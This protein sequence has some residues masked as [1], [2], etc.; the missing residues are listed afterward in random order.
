LNR[1]ENYNAEARNRLCGFS[2]I[3]NVCPCSCGACDPPPPPPPPLQ[4]GFWG[5]F[6]RRTADGLDEVQVGK[7]NEGR[8]VRQCMEACTTN[9]DCQFFL[10]KETGSNG[11]YL[12][13]CTLYS[14]EG[15]VCLRYDPSNSSV[16]NAYVKVPGGKLCDESSAAP[17]CAL[18]GNGACG[19]PYRK[20]AAAA[21]PPKNCS[22]GG[23]AVVDDD[24][25]GNAI[26]A[27]V[28]QAVDMLANSTDSTEPALEVVETPE[29]PEA[30]EAEAPAWPVPVIVAA[31][32]VFV[33]VAY[34]IK[35]GKV[36]LPELGLRRSLA[37]DSMANQSL[38]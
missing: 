5:P 7:R 8:T 28:Q 15:G 23:G 37:L 1:P 10:H 36:K 19:E 26:V 24:G 30:A 34:A 4:A 9:E 14:F 12:G 2:T 25:G 6:N 29:A 13:R 3:Y 33:G 27:V 35:R 38:L 21:G 31:V 11:L 17:A 22:A 32:L 18:C 16:H 20:V